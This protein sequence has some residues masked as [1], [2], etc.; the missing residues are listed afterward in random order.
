VVVVVV[1]AAENKKVKLLLIKIRLY[2]RRIFFIDFDIFLSKI[3]SIVHIGREKMP[4]VHQG[5]GR[6]LSRG[7]RKHRRRMK[8]EGHLPGKDQKKEMGRRDAA[9]RK[10]IKLTEERRRLEERM[11]RPVW[12][13]WW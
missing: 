1:A 5:E 12:K 6:V 11:S 2:F 9:R 10:K 7:E 8:A 4:K 13:K 3:I